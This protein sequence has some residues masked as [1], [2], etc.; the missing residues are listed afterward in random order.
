M[1][2]YPTRRAVWLIA[3]GAPVAAIL[4]AIVPALWAIGAAWALMLLLLLLL[5][6][7]VA[8]KARD[9]RLT[10]PNSAEIGAPLQLVLAVEFA[11]GIAPRSLSGN[12]GLDGRLADAGAV[13]IAMEPDPAADGVFPARLRSF[14]SA[15]APGTSA[16]SG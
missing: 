11:G 5:D 14:P 2:F 3:L 10:V 12:L 16:G 15:A 8:A 7:L 6:G 1:N 9:I 4:A 13:T